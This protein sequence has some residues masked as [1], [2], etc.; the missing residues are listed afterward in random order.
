MA[1]FSSLFKIHGEIDID[2]GGANKA[3]EGTTQKAKGS[4][5]KLISIFKRIGSAVAAAFATDRIISF[6]KAIVETTA[7]ID[8]QNSAFEQIMGDYSDTA[9]KKMHEV[10]SATGMV[11]SRLTKYM[12]SMTAKFKGL[13][14]DIEESTTLAQKGLRLAADAS[15]FWDMSL[16]EAMSHLNSFVNGSYEGGE[17]IGLFANETQMAAYAI[18]QGLVKDKNAWQNLNEA[19]KQSIRLQRALDQAMSSGMMGQASVEADQ[20]A[21]TQANLNEKWRQ[22]QAIIGEP[23]LQKAVTPAMAMLSKLIDR[24]TP[25]AQRL[26]D[27]LPAA[28][29]KLRR[30]GEFL[31]RTFYPAIQALIDLGTDIGNTFSP[32]IEAVTGKLREAA[33][34]MDELKTAAANVASFITSAANALSSFVGWLSGGTAGATAFKTVIVGVVAGLTAYKTVTL[35]LSAAQKVATAV[36][37]GVKLAQAALNLVMSMNPIGLVVA[38]IAALVAAFIYLWNTSDEF[39]DFWINLWDKIKNAAGAVVDWLKNAWDVLAAFFTVTITAKFTAFKNTVATVF[40]AV[41]SAITNPVESARDAVKAV[42]DKIKGFFS[43]LSLKLPNIKLPHFKITGSLS[44]A[45]PS[46]PKLS[47]Q[48][49]AK[50]MDTPMLLNAPAIFGMSSSGS[51]LGGGEA[52]QEVVSG[53]DTLMNMIRGAVGS[54]IASLSGGIG[55]LIALLERYLPAIA[56]MS[57]SLDGEALVGHMMPLID[58]GLGDINRRKERGLV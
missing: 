45:P 15:A 48:W 17:A 19:E 6:G 30:A 41:K 21:N 12:T 47:V 22:F 31:K 4:E 56:S 32:V 23:L 27:K 9:Q 10:A 42:V 40:N 50:A 46:V 44:L 29:D 52:G 53:T 34:T 54:E 1:E 33:P 49:Y 35:A 57:V 39:R 13:G 18:E 7:E 28:E 38:A 5:S 3:L 43:N 37:N 51:L 25:K 55:T 8:A 20:Y 36:T 2:T 11:D 24:I 14:F 16:D 26:I 58:K